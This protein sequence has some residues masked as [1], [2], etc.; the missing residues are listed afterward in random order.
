M[1]EAEPPPT[2]GDVAKAAGTMA[3]VLAGA[4]VLLSGLLLGGT[5]IIVMIVILGVIA[6]GAWTISW[7]LGLPIT[8][9]IL[10]LLMRFFQ[11]ED[12]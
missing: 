6:W 3:R 8:I 1:N 5:V 9:L 11:G 4:L 10:Y 2:A 7:V 12:I